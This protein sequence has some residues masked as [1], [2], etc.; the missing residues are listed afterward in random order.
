MVRTMGWKFV[1]CGLLLALGLAAPARPVGAQL[2]SGI[3]AVVNDDIIT[4][5]DVDR[6]Q[7]LLAKEAAKR[8]PLSPEVRVQLR[9]VALN[10]LIDRKL[11]DQKIKEL[12][13]KVSEEEI[14]Q[15]IEDVK[16]QNNLTQEALVSARAAQGLSYEQYRVQMK[17]QMER[18]RLMSQEVRAK[19]QVSERE[20]QEYYDANRASYAEDEQFRARQIFFRVKKDATA[21]DLKEILTRAMM[22]LQE[23]RGGADF[24]EL[25]KKYSDDPAAIKDGGD[26]GTFRKGDI[27]SEVEAEVVSMKPGEISELVSSTS[28]FHIIKLEERVPAKVKPLAEVKGQIE[29]T[30][31]KKKS[32]ERFNQWAA[33]LRKGAA[34]E[35]KQ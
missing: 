21:Q 32:E 8:G 10:R 25:A 31:F 24:A 30:L 20:I 34:I 29:E 7:A 18:I 9:S 16:K 6:E 13:I 4:T 15:A 14:R 3:A 28:G 2:I 35:I 27:V 11:V 26:L 23:A 5:L 19:I 12:D 33:E 22:V 17:E 1:V